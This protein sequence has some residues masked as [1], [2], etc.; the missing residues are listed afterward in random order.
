MI[1]RELSICDPCWDSRN[2]SFDHHWCRKALVGYWASYGIH[3]SI[4]C[5][6]PCQ[7]KE[8]KTMRVECKAS[9]L[10]D[11]IDQAWVEDLSG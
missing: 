8:E 9:E 2:R 3:A 7:R 4:S 10:H 1:E 11:R 6:C 5:D